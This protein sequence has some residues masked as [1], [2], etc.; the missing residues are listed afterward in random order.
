MTA[1]VVVFDLDGTLADVRH[2]LPLLQRRP[3]DWEA[4]FAAAVHDPP[5]AE[6]V[7]LAREKAREG[8]LAYVTGRP[9]RCRADTLAWLR[10]QDL[11]GDRLLMRAERDRRP[12]RVAKPELLR[13]LARE[14]PVLLVVDDDAQVCLAYERAGFPVLRADWMS[15][16]PVLEAVQEAEGRT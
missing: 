15:Q 12:A 10:E 2:R 3:R 6:G 1:P 14:R 13:H 5:L 4:F 7:A 16:E 9:E 8:E 11:P